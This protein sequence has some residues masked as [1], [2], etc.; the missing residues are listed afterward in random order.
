M[1]YPC[2]YN[3]EGINIIKQFS[4]DTSEGL[5]LNIVLPG[6]LQILITDQHHERKRSHFHDQPH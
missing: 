6:G 4:N 3:L 1:R 5:F 2:H